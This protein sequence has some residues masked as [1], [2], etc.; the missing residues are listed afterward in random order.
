MGKIL[1]ALVAIDSFASDFWL[2]KL[3]CFYWNPAEESRQDPETILSVLIHQLVR[4]ESDEVTL[5]RPIVDAYNLRK[6][7]GEGCTRLSLPECQDPR[8]LTDVYE[9]TKI[10]IDALDEVEP[11][12]GKYLLQVVKVV[13]EK[14]KNLVKISA[15]TRTEAGTTR[16][17]EMPPRIDPLPHVLHPKYYRVGIRIRTRQD[18]QSE[19][20]GN[21][22][23]CESRSRNRSRVVSRGTAQRNNTTSRESLYRCGRPGARGDTAAPRCQET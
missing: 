22:R 21:A 3:S 7:E 1:I 20:N 13:M 10:C 23:S 19:G 8:Q 18:K 9:Q 6:T 4:T 2:W 16:Q 5:L 17:F 15:T 14:S 11:S 12:T